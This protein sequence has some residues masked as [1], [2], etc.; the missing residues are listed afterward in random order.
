MLKSICTVWINVSSGVFAR[1]RHSAMKF[2]NKTLMIGWPVAPFFA[3]PCTWRT[4]GVRSRT[5]AVRPILCWCH[6]DCSWSWSLHSC[7]CRRYAD[8]CQLCS[9]RP[10]D[11]TRSHSGVC[12]RHRFLDDFDTFSRS[13]ITFQFIA[14]I[15]KILVTKNNNRPK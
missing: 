7:I 9:A 5:S 3:P 8:L 14:A 13:N 2:L 1:W 4:A 12:R 10:A 6:K 11:G 15:S